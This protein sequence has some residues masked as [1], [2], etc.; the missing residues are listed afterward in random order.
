MERKE[1]A[2]GGR[3]EL[4]LWWFRETQA[5][6]GTLPDWFTGFRSRRDSE[7]LLRDKSPGCFLVRLS[8]RAVGYILS[9]RGR[10]RCRHY[11]ITQSGDGRLVVSGDRR[12]HE[13]LPELVQHYRLRPIQPFGEYLTC[14]WRQVS[15]GELY[16]VVELRPPGRSGLSVQALRTLWD[17]N[18]GPPPGE[19]R[20]VRPPPESRSRKLTGTLSL[21][22]FNTAQPSYPETRTTSLPMLNHREEQEEEQEEELYSNQLSTPSS[23]TPLERSTGLPYSLHDPRDSSWSRSNPLYQTSTGS[24]GGSG[25]RGDATYAQVPRRPSPDGSYEPMS[26]AEIQGDPYESPEDL[27]DLR[28]TWGNH[29]GKNFLPDS[30]RQ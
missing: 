2:E 23:P 3:R 6:F 11:V 24:G 5:R 4:V 8:D 15:T 9:Y 12:T 7:D 25:L 29:H 28:S 20:R 27:K 1:R 21:T 19:T 22:Q 13:G 30:K 14:S 16:D 10:D 18:H 26:P 17:Q